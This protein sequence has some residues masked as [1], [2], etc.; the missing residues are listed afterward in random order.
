MFCRCRGAYTPSQP[1]YILEVGAGPG[2]FTFL[3]LR[4]LLA[5]HETRGEDIN[6]VYVISDFTKNNAAYWLGHEKLAPYFASG[7]LDYAIFDA[8]K[9][10]EIT[11]LKSGM[12]LTPGSL[13]NPIFAI[14]NYIFDTLRQDAFRI[15]EGQLQEAHAHVYSHVEGFL[16]PAESI[17]GLKV[18][19]SYH[20]C[21]PEV[22]SNP[23]LQNMLRVYA[24]RM[25][26]ASILVPIGGITAMSNIA[27]LSNGRLILLAGDKAYNHEEELVGLR[28]PHV[29][30]HGSF[31]FMVNFHA[32][33]LYTLARG[34]FCLQTPQ[35]D[36][37]KCNAFA[38]GLGGPR[39]DVSLR[40]P[41]TVSLTPADINTLAD[42]TVTESALQ[43]PEM[44]CA[45]AD[46]MDTFGPDNFSTLQRCVRDEIKT[47]SVKTALA[48]I[49]M[50]VWD[51]DV[52]YKFK[53]TI[54]EATPSASEKLQSDIHR[55]VTQILLRYF[56]LQH[57]KD[58]SFELARICMG[59]KR[60]HDAI[61]LF[62]ASR[63]QCGDHHVAWYN[64]GICNWYLSHWEEALKAFGKSLDMKPD[65]EDAASW[66]VRVEAKLHGDAFLKAASEGGEEG[67]G[68][69]EERGGE[70]VAAP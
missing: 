40:E 6:F 52:F 22:Y 4:E 69:G 28:D 12:H 14:C 27:G 65:Y 26:S 39:D 37:F 7:R 32:V 2:K 54:I 57:A 61:T 34:G 30:V 62:H 60:W 17:R 18:G 10:T 9:D 23:Y 45:W 51:S 63:R 70:A 31:S 1:I 44:L 59:L 25:K 20:H 8:E 24:M 16:Q 50:S 47:A 38:L 55:D 35:L 67:G 49:R 42:I 29:A 68:E 46:A 64:I 15:V 21:S 48:T 11:L 58:V 41:S 33:R 19:W 5:L 36:G 53:Q 3:L 56:P 13:S 66:K 43:Y